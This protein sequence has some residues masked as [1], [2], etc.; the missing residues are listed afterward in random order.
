MADERS[1]LVFV[2]DAA[3]HQF[4]VPGRRG[5]LTDIRRELDGGNGSDMSDE[6]LPHSMRYRVPPSQRAVHRGG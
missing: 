2:A 1:A 4:A 5:Q 3:Q 6:A